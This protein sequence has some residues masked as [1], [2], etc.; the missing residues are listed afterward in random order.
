MV[1]DAP[2]E[3]DPG[4]WSGYPYTVGQLYRC[5]IPIP[6]SGELHL[7][8]FLWHVNKTGATRTIWIALRT[9]SG[10]VSLKDHRALTPSPPDYPSYPDLYLR[11]RCL[12]KA[13]LFASITEAGYHTGTRI[14]SSSDVGL[15][16][17]EVVTNEA[18]TAIH[19]FTLE[20]SPGQ[21]VDLRTI[22]TTGSLFGDP[23]SQCL[24]PDH[25]RGWWP[26]SELLAVALPWDTGQLIEPA[27]QKHY[28]ICQSLGLDQQVFA[29]QGASADPFGYPQG[30]PSGNRGLYGVNARYRARL[31]NSHNLVRYV[32]FN[33]RA[34]NTG[35]PP[36]PYF[37]A[38]LALEEDASPTLGGVPAIRHR[39]S[40]PPNPYPDAVRIRNSDLAVP[41]NTT[42]NEALER[43]VKNATGGA[44]TMPVDLR[45]VAQPT[46]TPID[47]GP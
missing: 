35:T 11:G 47:N 19:E 7:R 21:V 5:S 40:P 34:R 9:V 2:E 28:G 10:S 1:S 41:A 44:A 33:L 15:G 24:L 25:I 8:V 20:G 13:Q 38:A 37:G 43:T 42:I 4:A 26:F 14:T 3:I 39:N 18:V 45:L 23:Y 30:S 36:P 17:H 16:N 46:T 31:H 27:N 29:W 32:S 22:I 12:A 6:T